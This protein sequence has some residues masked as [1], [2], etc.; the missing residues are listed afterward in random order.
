MSVEMNGMRLWQGVNT[1]SASRE[2]KWGWVTH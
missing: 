1:R 2:R